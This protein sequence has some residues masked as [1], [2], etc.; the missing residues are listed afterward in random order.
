MAAFI[1]NSLVTCMRPS[2][3]QALRKKDGVP[4]LMPLL[5]CWSVVAAAFENGVSTKTVVRDG[6]VLMEQRCFQQVNKLFRRLKCGNLEERIWNFDNP[7][8]ANVFKTATNSVGLGDVT[9]YQTRHSG[10][11]IDPVRGFRTLQE[12][13]NRRQRRASSSVARYH[14]SSRPSADYHSLPLTLC[15]QNTLTRHIFS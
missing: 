9:V 14:K 2:E 10:A 3:P 1:L 11:G 6:L 13:Q 15:E 8:A 7:A 12:V 5:P 4:P